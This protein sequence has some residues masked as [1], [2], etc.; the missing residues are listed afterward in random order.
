MTHRAVLFF[1]ALLLASGCIRQQAGNVRPGADVLLDSEFALIKGKRVGL[2]TNHSALLSDGRH[3]ADALHASPDVKLVVL[4]G[5]EHGIRGDAPDGRT[6]RDS[7]DAATGIP[8]YSLYGAIRK[9]TP[10][11]LRDVDVLLFDIQDIGARFYTYISTM[12]YAMEAAAEQHIP[13]VVL[14][15]PNPIR[16][17]W[18][19]GFIRDDSLRS[20]VG[21]HPIPIA[22][23]MTVGELAR[24]FNGEGWLAEGVQADLTVVGMEGWERSLWYDETGLKWVRPSPNMATLNTAVVYPGTCLIE[25]TNLSEGRGTD[26]PFEYLGAPFVDGTRWAERLNAARLPGVTFEPVAFTPREIPRVTA[27]PKY[28]DLD[29]S[30]ILVQVTD[31]DRYE[32]VRTGVHILSSA[33]ALFAD[34]L[35]WREGAIDR[36]SGTKRLRRQIDTGRNPEDIVAGWT[37]EVRRFEE[38]R[39]QYLL[40]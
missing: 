32:P 21:L 20:F 15:R 19:E 33:K 10:E 26:R 34:S 17:T 23:G 11:M 2:V 22:H 7:I 4:F 12:S 3:L 29:C 40:Y 16:G 8:V 28:R 14:D 39:K 36:L 27:N 25:G 5:P 13:F 6:V 38:M 37:Q 31:R 24:M 9:P 1:A 18:V 35:R 30:G